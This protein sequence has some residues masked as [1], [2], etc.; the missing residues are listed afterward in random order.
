[1]GILRQMKMG[2]I[3][4]FSMK[5]DLFS[6]VFLPDQ[7]TL[8]VR[9]TLMA[10]RLGKSSG[11]SNFILPPFTLAAVHPL[12]TGHRRSDEQSNNRVVA[13]LRYRRFRR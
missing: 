3:A 6:P 7:M 11:L 9:Q 5:E 8:P 13:L 2:E 12:V 1:L 4:L 10:E